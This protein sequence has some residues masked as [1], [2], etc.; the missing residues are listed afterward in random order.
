VEK[1]AQPAK[2]CVGKH[3]SERQKERGGKVRRTAPFLFGYTKQ[4]QTPT[5]NDL[6]TG[7]GGEDRLAMDHT[8]VF[9]VPP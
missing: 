9:E 7:I 2:K 1:K 8:E 6:P 5:T 4:R 3:Q